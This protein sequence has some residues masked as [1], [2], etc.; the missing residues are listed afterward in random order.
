M[1]SQPLLLLL[2]CSNMFLGLFLVCRWHV[3]PLPCLS[4]AP[5]CCWWL[6]RYRNT[7]KQT[8]HFPSVFLTPL[9]RDGRVN[10]CV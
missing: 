5:S 7:K 10:V 6:V 9:L 2:L 4:I 8:L 3:L 1:H